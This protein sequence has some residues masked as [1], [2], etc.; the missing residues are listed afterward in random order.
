MRKSAAVALAV[1]LALTGAVLAL[2]WPRPSHVTQANFDR[3]KEGMGRADVEAL[4]GP[5]GD[6]TTGPTAVVLDGV[7]F[8]WPGCTKESWRGDEGI[9]SVAF[10]PS[11][12][13]EA[14]KFWPCGRVEIGPLDRL[15]WRLG[16]RWEAL[17]R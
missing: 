10:G 1:A 9:G 6:Y 3:I 12:K 2:A 15:L 8:G 16:R 7:R 14:K 13:V 5:P 11:G 17:A 4:L